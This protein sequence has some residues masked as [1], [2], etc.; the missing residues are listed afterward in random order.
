LPFQ[1]PAVLVQIDLGAACLTL[2][3]S[4]SGRAERGQQDAY[5][6][7]NDRNDDQNLDQGKGTL[8][9]HKTL[10]LSLSLSLSFL[11]TQSHKTPPAAQRV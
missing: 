1:S 11:F 3:L 7:G 4:A 6:Q 9:S 5:Q 10:S 2:T 8:F